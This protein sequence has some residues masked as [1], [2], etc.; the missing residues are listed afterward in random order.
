MSW[1]EG[2]VDLSLFAESPTDDR[3]FAVPQSFATQGDV[4]SESAH[5]ALR[6]F[7]APISP[8]EYATKPL[9]PLPP[10]AICSKIPRSCEMESGCILN[11]LKRNRTHTQPESRGNTL[12]QRRNVT[13]TP[14]LTLS[15]PQTIPGHQDSPS[16]MVWM[17]DEQMW[18]LVS[19]AHPNRSNNNSNNSNIHPTTPAYTSRSF[20]RS[21]PSPRSIPWDHP[22]PP[23]TPLQHQFQS[24]IHPRD[25]ERLSPLFQEAM[26]SVPMTDALDLPPPPFYDGPAARPRTSTAGSFPSSLSPQPSLS[27][28]RSTHSHSPRHRPRHRPSTS[29]T[30]ASLATHAAT[31]ADSASYH[32]AVSEMPHETTAGASHSWQGVARRIAR[33]RS[34]T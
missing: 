18:L 27:R 26:N 33:P 29:G 9:P 16:A 2:L 3:H 28:S 6:E 25:E 19:E 5:P 23:L 7:Y 11:R 24:L 21:E 4:Y 12:L 1:N 34:A 20:T 15:V 31:E 13:S 17:P 32:T 10:R 8:R 14:Q 30:D 22:T